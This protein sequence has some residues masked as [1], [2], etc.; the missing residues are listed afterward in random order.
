MANLKDSGL[1]RI[2][3]LP[4]GEAPEIVR[5]AWL[6][7]IL[8]CSPTVGWSNEG[9]ELKVLSGKKIPKR[10]GFSVP[11]AEAIKILSKSNRKAAT[12]WKKHGFPQAG[13]YFGFDESEAEILRGVTN[14]RIFVVNDLDYPHGFG[15]TCMEC[16]RCI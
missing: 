13:K 4:E 12:W 14:Q 3:K 11:Q 7:L 6:G 16:L 9:E 8:P 15:A 5:K 2:I 10:Y 1:I